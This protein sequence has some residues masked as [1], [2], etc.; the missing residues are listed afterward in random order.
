MKKHRVIA[1]A[2]Q[3]SGKSAGRLVDN[4]ICFH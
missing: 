1:P 3:F 4:N 2:I